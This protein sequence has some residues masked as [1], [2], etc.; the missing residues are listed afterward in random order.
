MLDD[1]VD[2]KGVIIYPML[3]NGISCMHT[4]D[5]LIKGFCID[6]LLK[7]VSIVYLFELAYHTGGKN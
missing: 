2:L 1:T 7:Y 6:L 3:M 4:I 5:L